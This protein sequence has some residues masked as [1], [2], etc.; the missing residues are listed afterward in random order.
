LD[1]SGCNRTAADERKKKK[2]SEAARK[3]A[4]AE[5]A[6]NLDEE[7][8]GYTSANATLYHN[9]D[10]EKTDSDDDEKADLA[11]EVQPGNHRTG[12][13]G[14]VK[15]DYFNPP[16]QDEDP[17]CV[18]QGLT[19]AG[20]GMD[21]YSMGGSQDSAYEY[22]PKQYILLGGLV[23]KYRDM[24]EKVA[25]A[26]KKYL[27]YRPMI[28]SKQDILFSAR[29]YSRD[30]TDQDLSHDYEITHLT[31]FL[32]GMF[33]LGART[34]DRPE[35]LE[36]AKK[37]TD[38]CVWAYDIMPSGLMPESALIM[39]CKD[40]EN[41][42]WEE[43]KWREKLDPSA[44]W[45]IQ[46]MQ[47]SEIRHKEW[48][49]Q[50]EGILEKQEAKAQANLEAEEEAKRLRP[51][52]ASEPA[53]ARERA[54][55]QAELTKDDFVS[56]GEGVAHKAPISGSSAEADKTAADKEAVSRS[57]DSS[58][59]RQYEKR[60]LDPEAQSAYAANSGDSQVSDAIA[61][62]VKSL[63]DE[64]N[65]N[66]GSGRER[67]TGAFGGVKGE[68]PY[69]PSQA[70]AQIPLVENF[71]PPEPMKPMTHDEYIDHRLKTEHLPEG[72]V[73]LTDKRYILR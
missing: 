15:R 66:G 28:P 33:G 17:E 46:Q 4:E 45:R 19:R 24:H 18:P 69:D 20:Y 5:A 21:S 13:H 12:S 63:E 53:T 49:K 67:D 27:L 8:Q 36:V 60:G 50:K 41:C 72:F 56:G 9:H 62:K 73:S 31:C 22:F 51:G 10:S 11:F 59:T 48:Q 2:A 58:R 68:I 29:V 70:R 14:V 6:K 1:A 30:G 38:G 47:D 7:P 23:Q 35:D 52:N 54:S 55:E 26:V 71:I 43:R 40:A 16:G 3:Q 25:D 57:A 44:Q 32:G 37:L 65:L 34:F 61:Q 64:L 39:P 42:Q